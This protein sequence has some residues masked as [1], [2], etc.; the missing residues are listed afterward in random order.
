MIAVV[1][2]YDTDTMA[3][4]TRLLTSTGPGESRA[5]APSE[6]PELAASIGDRRVVTWGGG[7]W[8]EGAC[9]EHA[10]T[11]VDLFALFVGQREWRVGVCCLLSACVLTPG[12][13]VRCGFRRPASREPPEICV[14]H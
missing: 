10:R 6:W 9:P 11:Q 2:A 5:W 4:P 7:R 1:A 3:V 14:Y 12:E 13:P 8:L